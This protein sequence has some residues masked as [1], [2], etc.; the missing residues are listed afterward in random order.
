MSQSVISVKFSGQDKIK[1]NVDTIRANLPVWIAEANRETGAEIRDE[2]QANVK[3]IDAFDTGE[4]YNSIRMEQSAGGLAVVIGST[5]KHAP[6]IEFGTAPHWPPI[7]KIRAWCIRKGIPEGAAF[8]IARAISIRGTPERP[9]LYPAFR[10][11]MRRYIDRLRGVVG[12][13]LRKV[14]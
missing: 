11:G 14:A 3:Q 12:M 9:W 4:L 13:G 1:V 10:V 8:P 7:D 5:A 2:A 6:F